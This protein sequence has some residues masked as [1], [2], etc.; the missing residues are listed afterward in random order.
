[1]DLDDVIGP[2]QSTAPGGHRV[3]GKCGDLSTQTIF[4]ASLFGLVA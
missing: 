3:G 2:T 1:M 4:I